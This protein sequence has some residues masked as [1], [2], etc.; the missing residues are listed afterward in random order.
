M[1]SHRTLS[2]GKVGR[3]I[4]V[5]LD[6]PSTPNILLVAGA[7]SWSDWIPDFVNPSD[8]NIRVLYEPT[9]LEQI[10]ERIKAEHFDS[11]V[12]LSH[13]ATLSEDASRAEALAQ[14]F[15]GQIVA[16]PHSVARIAY[17]KR[18]MADLAAQQKWVHP[19]PELTMSH[20]ENL[21]GDPEVAVIIKPRFGTEGVGFR[22][23]ETVEELRLLTSAETDH[24][25]IQPFLQGMEYSLNLYRTNDNTRCYPIVGKGFN[26]RQGIH[27]SKRRRFCPAQTHDASH[28][29]AMQ[30]A[31]VAMAEAMDI[32]GVCEFEFIVST[33]GEIYLVEI[34]PR[35]AATM[36]M[37]SLAASRSIFDDFVSASFVAGGGLM[38]PTANRFA[39]E[40]PVPSEVSK[41][42]PKGRFAHDLWITSRFTV[43][44]DSEI[45]L[46]MRIADIDHMV[47][48]ALDDIK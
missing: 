14:T 45:S 40:L 44:A 35:V 33:A 25:I 32:N 9:H 30:H 4:T 27:P 15:A 28:D 5:S 1:I 13:H 23:V 41:M 6:L 8:I 7:A 37:A 22:V 42:F 19:I 34:N 11:I 2:D 38:P 29:I 47:R 48:A 16:Q 36:R 3:N 20:A 10:L 18:L 26:S 46:A 17:D 24:L 43:V 31:A 21:L 39:A 12:F